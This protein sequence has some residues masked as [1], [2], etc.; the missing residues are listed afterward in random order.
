MHF[1]VLFFITI[2]HVP[3][4][5]FGLDSEDN[6]I[7]EANRNISIY[8]I[9]EILIDSIN[10]N[11]SDSN[12]RIEELKEKV[13]KIKKYVID[14]DVVNE[15]LI[16]TTRETNLTDTNFCK[17]LLEEDHF[18]FL[19]EKNASKNLYSKLKEKM[20]RDDVL[21]ILDRKEKNDFIKSARKAMEL[22]GK[23]EN[24][25]VNEVIDQIIAEVPND[26]HEFEA[27]VNDSKYW[28]K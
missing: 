6:E 12:A 25:V 7:N 9:S 4:E 11:N 22:S 27:T 13:K 18:R 21:D 19:I 14:N 2:C 24:D 26:N 23:A 8:N 10:L 17:A 20:T 16:N 1:Q 28:G 5:L 15:L 3:K